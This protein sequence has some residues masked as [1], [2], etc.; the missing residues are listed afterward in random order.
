MFNICC[1]NVRGLNDP[2]KRCL[3]RHV[4]SSLRNVVVC[5]QESKVRQVSCSFLRSFAGPFLDKR[6]FIEAGAS[7]GLITCWSSKIFECSEVFVRNFS[8]T[9]HLLHRG[10]GERFFVTNAYG[11]QS[12]EGKEAFGVELAQLKLCCGG[13]W[14]ICGDFNLTRARF[15]R[16]GGVGGGRA[17]GMFNDLI[18][19]LEM[20]DLPLQN[21]SFTW[22]NM[23]RH[24]SL[25]KLDRFLVSTEWDS[26]FPLSTVE[27]LPRIT[28]DHCPILLSTGGKACRPG[29]VFRLEVAWL[30]CD[31]FVSRFHNWWKEVGV[32]GSGVLNFTSKL[33]HCRRRIKA[34]CASHFYSIREVKKARTLEIKELDKAEEQGGSPLTC[35]TE[36]PN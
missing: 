18:S 27:A 25:A 24:P 4:I 11:P 22:S 8:I 5:L 2:S 17:A 31:D 14:V 29:K 28:S 33:R 20:I 3:V 19:A 10:S 35:S 34:W 7:G 6:Q 15:E 13:N 16:N 21:Q 12:G 26:T 9:V 30:K 32:S 36:G 23:Q 1:W